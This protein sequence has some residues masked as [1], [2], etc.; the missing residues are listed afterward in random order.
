MIICFVFSS[1]GVTK[2]IDEISA[3]VNSVVEKTAVLLENNARQNSSTAQTNE[4]L[5][6]V[7]RFSHDIDGNSDK[8]IDAVSM[9]QSANAEI[10]NNISNVSAVS[11]EVAAQASAT[12]EEAAK[13]LI[14]VDDMME[15]VNR[16]S[17]SAEIINNF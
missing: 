4:K 6:E 7:Q 15:I 2:L 13:N 5:V 10:V 8:L 1:R 17:E 16:L 9:L 3:Q 14:V 11:Q 12:Y